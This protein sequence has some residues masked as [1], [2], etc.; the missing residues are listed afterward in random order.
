[1]SAVIGSLF[2]KLHTYSQP[3]AGHNKQKSMEAA[4]KIVK[5]SVNAAQ[6]VPELP[7]GVLGSWLSAAIAKNIGLTAVNIHG[8]RHWL[9]YVLIHVNRTYQ[10]YSIIQHL[11]GTPDMTRFTW[12]NSL[13]YGMGTR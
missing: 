1:M 4:K 7:S 8:M 13:E 12:S 5:N 9:N 2:L 6:S 11:L 3:T 10:A